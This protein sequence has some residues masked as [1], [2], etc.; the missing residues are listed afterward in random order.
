MTQL[1]K[2]ITSESVLGITKLQSQAGSGGMGA[3]YRA[4]RAD[5]QFHQSV[6]IKILKHGYHS[7]EVIHRFRIE[8]EILANL[9]HPNIAQ[10]YDA[11]LTDDE[12]PYLIMEFV[13]GIPIDEYANKHRLINQ[14]N[15]W[16]FFIKSL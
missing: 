9:H 10:L 2:I 1:I 12:T 5:G 13:D 7:D 15:G 8:Q 3:V 4:E 16:I 11:G 6:A 14:S